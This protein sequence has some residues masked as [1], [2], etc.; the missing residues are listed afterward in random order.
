MARID[1]VGYG[2]EIICSKITKTPVYFKEHFPQY[3]AKTEKDKG[4]GIGNTLG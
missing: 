1:L 4:I 3:A 2:E